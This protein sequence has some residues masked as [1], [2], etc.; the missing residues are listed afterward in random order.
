MSLSMGRSRRY[1]QDEKDNAVG[2]V[3]LRRAETGEKHGSVHAVA[4]QLGFGSESVR[5][6][7][8]QADIA[9][10]VTAGTS[11]A[12]ADKMKALEQ[13]LK[14]V[15]RAN[16]RDSAEFEVGV[17]FLRGGTR[18]PTSMMV[19]YI[20]NIAKCSESSRSATCCRLLCPPTMT[21]RPVGRVPALFAMRR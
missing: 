10:G 5:A 14:E 2:L 21:T 18:P 11:T 20:D 8:R 1:K 3:R 17:G 4:A 13:E 7:V 16:A 9:D 12:D 6:W 15:K 19:D